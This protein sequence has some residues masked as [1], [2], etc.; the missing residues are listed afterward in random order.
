MVIDPERD[1]DRYFD[2][3]ARLKLRIV[4]AAIPIFTP[5]TSRACGRWRRAA[6]SS[7]VEGG[8]PRVAMRVADPRPGI[9]TGCLATATSSRSGHR[10]PRRFHAW[11][12]PEH[13]SYLVRDAGGGAGISSRSPAATSSSSA[14]S[15][16]R[17]CWN[18]RREWSA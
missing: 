11:P 5:T 16:G 14:T 10:I 12:Y 17:T 13:L 3:A 9:R 1:V 8:R 4:A 15:A 7:C 2:L 6:C 18:G